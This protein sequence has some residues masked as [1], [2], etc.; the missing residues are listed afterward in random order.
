M[1]LLLL[2]LLLLLFMC[3]YCYFSFTTYRRG[4]QR[5]PTGIAVLNFASEFEAHRGLLEKNKQQFMGR[6]LELQMLN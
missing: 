5:Q 6:D 1:I 4:I 2:L 3:C